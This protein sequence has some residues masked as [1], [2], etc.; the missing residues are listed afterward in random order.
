M[1]ED[2]I[3]CKWSLTVIDLIRTGTKRPG[4][5]Q[6]SVEGLTTKVL[7]ERL[8]KLVC[9]G[10]IE[11]TIFAEVPPRVEYN[12]TELGEK[13]VRILDAINNLEN[14]FLEE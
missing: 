13:F 3:G 12:L 7:N 8:R 5:M 11:K 1:V 9:F 10:V 2:V 4:E 6:R 14:E